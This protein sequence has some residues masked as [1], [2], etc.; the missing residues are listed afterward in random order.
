MDASAPLPPLEVQSPAWAEASF[1]L[2]ELGLEN[3]AK[4]VDSLA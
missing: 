3:V 4:R 2:R 1:F